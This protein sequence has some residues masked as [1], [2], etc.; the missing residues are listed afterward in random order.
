MNFREEP[1]EPERE[2]SLSRGRSNVDVN[3]KEK[4]MVPN[5]DV[6]DVKS[7]STGDSATE[8]EV[9]ETKDRDRVCISIS[10]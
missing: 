9:V 5:R 1:K 4:P 7:T 8:K 3:K 10:N 2:N 6:D